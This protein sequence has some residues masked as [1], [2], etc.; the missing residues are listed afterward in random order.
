MI[1][2][3][4][5]DVDYAGVELF[6]VE[7]E[8]GF[9][10]IE[11]I[12]KAVSDTFENPEIVCTLRGPASFITAPDVISIDKYIYEAAWWKDDDRLKLGYCNKEALAVIEKAR[13]NRNKGK[14]EES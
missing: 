2:I 4:T 5:H 7:S 9:D 10:T 3:I 11:C 13:A 1:Y 8:L 6:F 14:K 12:T